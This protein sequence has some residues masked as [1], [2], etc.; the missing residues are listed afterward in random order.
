MLRSLTVT[1]TSDE[2]LVSSL[3]KKE[4][5]EM[6]ASAT[7]VWIESLGRIARVCM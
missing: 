3:C 2:R 4:N 1:S 6:E 5:F 7:R